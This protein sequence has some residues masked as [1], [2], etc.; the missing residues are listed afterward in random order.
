MPHS[1]QRM[2]LEKIVRAAS[3][4]FCV[5]HVFF[6]NWDGAPES[7]AVQD[8]IGTESPLDAER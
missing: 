4:Q 7:V 5:D 2:S 8:T 3:L 6:T 1:A